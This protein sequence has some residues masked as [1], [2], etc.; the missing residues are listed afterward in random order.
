MQVAQAKENELQNELAASQTRELR[1]L[2][3][4]K[5]AIET[6]KKVVKEAEG[7]HKELQDRYVE[8]SKLAVLQGQLL[9][10]EKK[11]GAEMEAKV[12]EEKGK[13]LKLSALSKTLAKQR[14]DLSAQVQAYSTAC[15]E[16]GLKVDL[17]PAAAVSATAT[18]EGAQEHSA[19]PQ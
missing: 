11:K 15:A 8:A 9:E 19:L 6:L 2:K 5:E 16:A 12:E 18:A 10:L 14:A 13:A 3:D 4:S 7:R 17:S 1:S